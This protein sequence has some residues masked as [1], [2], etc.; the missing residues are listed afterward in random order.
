M[1][2]LQTDGFE[3]PTPPMSGNV[4]GSGSVSR[5]L[6]GAYTELQAAGAKGLPSEE[7]LGEAPDGSKWSG[8]TPTGTWS[9]KKHNGTYTPEIKTVQ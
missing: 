2:E 1:P 8:E 5:E 6:F 4:E 7:V 3:H 9:L